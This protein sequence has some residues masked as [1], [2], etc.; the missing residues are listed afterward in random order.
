[1]TLGVLNRL[2][3]WWR[4]PITRRERIRSACIGA[5]AGIWVGLLVCVLLTSEPVGLGELGI[6]ALLGAL[7]CA[8][9]GALFPRVVGIILFPLSICGIGN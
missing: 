1:M 9:L 7:V 5:V 2:Q 3:L 4:S 8:G 6:W